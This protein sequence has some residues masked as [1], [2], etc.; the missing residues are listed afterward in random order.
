MRLQRWHHFD[1]A[2]RRFATVA[3]DTTR[4]GPGA[5]HRVELRSAAARDRL[6]ALGVHQ[7]TI[8]LITDRL[9]VLDGRTGAVGRC[10]VAAEP[11]ADPEAAE[12]VIDEPLPEVPEETTSYSP[13]PD[14]L[15]LVRSG[16]RHPAYLQ[17]DID[18]TGADI[19]VRGPMEQEVD[20]ETL[21]GDHDVIHKVRAGE[22][23]EQRLQRRAEDS[24]QRNAAAVARHLDGLVTRHRPVLIAVA[25][26]ERAM[27][28]LREQASAG[29]RSLLE[30]LDSGGR[31]AGV[32]QGAEGDALQSALD[33]AIV[34]DVERATAR[35]LQAEGRQDRAAQGRDG[36]VAAFARGQ[37]ETLLLTDPPMSDETVTVGDDGLP[38]AEGEG[39]PVGLAMAFAAAAL[40]TDAEVVLV[41]AETTIP[42]GAG[43][44][45]RWDDQATP[46]DSGPSMPG[47]GEQPGWQ[48]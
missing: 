41:P 40:A 7:R 35:M 13:V 29:V 24:W 28:A 23:S 16:Q 19:L 46:H 31:A 22:A 14:L 9:T 42:D 10:V 5:G 18:R 37:V 33:A 32:D 1:L 25:G 17:V 21:S 3:I 11:T 12:V 44:V 26:D 36:L 45:L 39:E 27:S 48:P 38:R 20:A 15:P 8:E 6:A 4:D 30:P 2:D 47:H 43:A 34:R